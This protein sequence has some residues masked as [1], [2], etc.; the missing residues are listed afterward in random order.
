MRVFK[1]NAGMRLAVPRKEIYDLY[2]YFAAERQAA[3]MR[4][5][6]GEPGPWSA[7]PILAT[8]KFCNVFRASDRVSQYLI[9]TVAYGDPGAKA[10]DTLFRIIAF[11]MFS[12]NETWEAVADYLGHQPTLADLHSGAF[13]QALVAAQDI[14]GKLYT[15]AFILCAN[16]AYGFGKKYRNHVALFK[17]MFLAGNLAER[18]LATTGL[19]EMYELIK[20]YPLL[21]DFMAYQIAIDLNYS[22]LINF[23]E[24]DFTKAGPGAKR[25]IQKAFS[26]TGNLTDEQ[27]I[28]LM[29]ERQDA[30]FARLGLEFNGL[31]GRKLHAI[32]CQ[33]LFCEL[34]KYCREAAPQLASNRT[35]IKA[36]FSPSAEPITLYYPP[37]WGLKRLSVS[38]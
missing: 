29:V 24:N 22:S 11:R 23:D 16:Q 28:H 25:G 19:K 10:E 9:R 32:D 8:Y 20:S 27:I 36:H 26:D 34:D 3:F 31:W 12:K 4:R 30:E 33:G 13:E 17:D 6:R 21:G 38:R 15:G 35:R 5:V 7:D 1:Y 2:W 14:N 18:L 37:K